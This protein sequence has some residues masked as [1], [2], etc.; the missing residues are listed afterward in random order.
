MAVVDAVQQRRKM[1]DAPA[2]VLFEFYNR[3]ADGRHDFLR[4]VQASMPGGEIGDV[5]QGVAKPG[6]LVHLIAQQAFP[7]QALCHVGAAFGEFVGQRRPFQVALRGGGDQARV[8][9]VFVKQLSLG[10]ATE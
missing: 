4:L 9:A 8:H 10:V 7:I 1:G 3:A 6:Q 5:L 2:Q